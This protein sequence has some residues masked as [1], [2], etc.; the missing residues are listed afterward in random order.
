VQQG[1]PIPHGVSSRERW[2]FWFPVFAAPGG[3]ESQ[4]WVAARKQTLLPDPSD[5]GA[6]HCWV[7]CAPWWSAGGY[8]IPPGF[9]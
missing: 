6:P 5:Q 7:T 1:A 8:W 2:W 3:H 4:I 9:F